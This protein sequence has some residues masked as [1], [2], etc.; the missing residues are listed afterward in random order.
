MDW[1]R[2]RVEGI[3]AAGGENPFLRWELGRDTEAL[4]SDVG[5]ASLELGND[6]VWGTVLVATSPV[7]SP[8]M[9]SAIEGLSGL[10]AERDGELGWISYSGAIDW[11]LRDPWW[12]GEPPDGA[13]VWMSTT[14]LASNPTHPGL[15]ELDDAADAAE[16]EAFG[17]LHNP[18]FEG[19]PGSGRNLFWYGIRD[20]DGKLIACGTAHRTLAGTGH[21]SGIVVD[22]ARRREGL[23]SVIVAA[24]S[25]RL[26][27]R[28]GIAILSAYA[29]NHGAIALYEQMGYAI[30]HR[31]ALRSRI[32]RSIGV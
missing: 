21:L 3:L 20:D 32:S 8:T 31:F 28:Y 14:E 23:G 7:D 1:Q 12:E 27:E 4:V 17:R 24:L 30:G 11:Q 18:L 5:W 13:W 10:V 26:I 22:A 29:T 19:Y 9:D 15:V 16:L 2:T 25:R 6:K